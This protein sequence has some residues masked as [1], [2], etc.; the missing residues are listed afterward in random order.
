MQQLHQ[1]VKEH[2]PV[3]TLSECE[4]YGDIYFRGWRTAPD[5][6][7]TDIEFVIQDL[8]YN[9]VIAY[10]KPLGALDCAVNKV[11]HLFMT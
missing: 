3:S 9:A 2:L 4:S 5:E 10:R 7:K 8:M 6:C 1:S 11:C